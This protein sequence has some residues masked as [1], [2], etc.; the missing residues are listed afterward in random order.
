MSTYPHVLMLFKRFNAFIATGTFFSRTIFLAE[1]FL[2]QKNTLSEK[3]PIGGTSISLLPMTDQTIACT[4][5]QFSGRKD[6][7]VVIKKIEKL[8]TKIYILK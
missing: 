8:L 4:I 2:N 1:S 5:I 6:L 3:E 7:L